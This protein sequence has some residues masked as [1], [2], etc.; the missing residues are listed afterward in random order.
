MLAI[1]N[2][3]K[4][5]PSQAWIV[6][7]TALVTSFIALISV[8]LT[9][10]A[11]NQRLKI[12]FDTEKNIRDEDLRR[13]RLEE[14][15]ILSNKYLNRLV[16]YYLPYRMVMKGELTF[17]QALDITIEDGSKKEY[18]PHR[19]TM[20]I[21]MYFP[22]VKP[23]FDEIMAIREK[24]NK[25]ISDYKEQYKRGD[26]DGSRWLV[27]FQPLLSKIGILADSFDK[28]IVNLNR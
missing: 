19:V 9:S 22:E 28:N 8:W 17:N 1:L 18:D 2:L 26:I 20:L 4:S 11:N 16:G 25:I 23:A 6:F 12:Q 24:M 15:Y 21:H 3:L 14:L 5:I 10:R 13:N 27:K 7:I